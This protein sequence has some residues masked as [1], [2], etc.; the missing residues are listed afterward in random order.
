MLVV[1]S[2]DAEMQAALDRKDDMLEEIRKK[3]KE[4]QKDKQ[5]EIIKL[6]MEVD[7]KLGLSKYFLIQMMRILT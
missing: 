2:K 3:I 5:S 7:R 1:D 6:Q 4:Q